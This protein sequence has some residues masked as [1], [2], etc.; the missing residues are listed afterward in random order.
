MCFTVG[1]LPQACACVRGGLNMLR[2]WDVD[3]WRRG[4]IGGGVVL[5]QE[6]CHCGG[7][8]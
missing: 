4:I 5:L 8:L 7:G 3:I 2:Q 1:K 6:V